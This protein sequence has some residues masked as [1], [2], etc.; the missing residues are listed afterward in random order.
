MAVL[1]VVI[2]GYPSEIGQNENEPKQFKNVLGAHPKFW[3]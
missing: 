3:S 2:I 1:H